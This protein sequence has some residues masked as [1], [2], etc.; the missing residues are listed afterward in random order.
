MFMEFVVL[1]DQERNQ[2][3]S[4]LL[5]VILVLTAVADEKLFRGNPEG[6]IFYII[7]FFL[8]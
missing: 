6:E 5:I 3:G 1:D 8:R 7:K 4:M 2:N